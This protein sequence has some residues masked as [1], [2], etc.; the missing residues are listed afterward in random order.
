MHTYS[1]F[2]GMVP[3]YAVPVLRTAFATQG[4]PESAIDDNGDI[5]Y[6]ILVSSVVHNVELKTTVMPP[7]SIDLRESASAPP[8]AL[9]KF[10]KPTLVMTGPR[11]GRIVTAPYG[12][13]EGS[14]VGPIVLGLMGATL[15]AL[16]IRKYRRKK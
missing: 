16:V 11:I 12:E 2:D 3:S 5:D 8:S 4:I 9:A 13:A 10:L 1:A 15:G 14:W 7:Y 6:G